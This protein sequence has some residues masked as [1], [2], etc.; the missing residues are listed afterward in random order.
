MRLRQLT[1]CKILA[2]RTNEVLGNKGVHDGIVRDVGRT[3]YYE[4]ASKYPL[5]AN[6]A[7]TVEGMKGIFV[8]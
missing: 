8:E 2:Q 7:G 6:S 3:I 1:P 5:S 4:F